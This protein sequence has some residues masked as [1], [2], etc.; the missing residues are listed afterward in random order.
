MCEKNKYT[1]DDIAMIIAD[2]EHGEWTKCTCECKKC[3]LNKEIPI[4]II[5]LRKLTIC[6]IL[7]EISVLLNQIEE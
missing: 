6:N 4:S 2:W 5:G 1:Q 7:T 3:P